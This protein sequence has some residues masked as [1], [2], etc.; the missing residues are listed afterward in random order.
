[1]NSLVVFEDIKMLSNGRKVDKNHNYC[2][3]DDKNVQY[4]DEDNNRNKKNQK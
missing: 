2:L 1:M 4:D 3:I